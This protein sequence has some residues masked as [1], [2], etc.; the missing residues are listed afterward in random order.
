MGGGGQRPESTSR[1]EREREARGDAPEDDLAVELCAVRV[2]DVVLVVA[3]LERAVVEQVDDGREVVQADAGRAGASGRALR[4]GLALLLGVGAVV[5][6]GGL[7]VGVGVG[8]TA[9]ERRGRGG[10]RG[11]VG[12]LRVVD[13]GLL[14]RRSSRVDHAGS[15]RAFG[16]V[17]ERERDEGEP[18]GGPLL[19]CIRFEL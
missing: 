10:G 6:L 5:G 9:L 14:G 16:H 13:L 12:G 3:R 4:V 2:C 11:L 18:A 19:G 1:R 17:R 7:V 15:R 8:C